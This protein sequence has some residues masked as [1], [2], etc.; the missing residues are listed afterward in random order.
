[1]KK[2]SNW[3]RLD[4]QAKIFPEVY[5]KREPHMF[6]IQVTLNE[7]IEK[8]ILQAAV[9]HMLQR[10]PMFKVKLSTGFFW[11]Y[12]EENHKPFKVT[13]MPH[14]INQYMDFRANNDYLMR[15]FYRNQTIAVEVFHTLTD[16]TGLTEFVKS[17]AFEYL[18]LKGYKISPD[19]M[20]M[21]KRE[22]P[23]QDEA[24]DPSIA[25]YNKK[26]NK[27]IKEKAPFKVSGTYTENYEIK[28]IGGNFKTSDLIPLVKENNTT[29]TKYIAAVLI[30]SIYKTMIEYRTQLRKNQHPIKI[31]VPVNLRKRFPS[32]TMRNFVNIVSV[33]ADVSRDNV[34]FEEILVMVE[35]ELT[36]KTSQ[37]ELTRIMSEYVSYEKNILVRMIP[38]FIKKYFLKIGYKLL[39]SSLLTMTLSNVGK[40]DYPESMKPYIK[41]MG[42]ML[43]SGKSTPLNCAVI[44]SNNTLKVSFTS[45][46]IESH[47]Q[48]EFFRH[49]TQLG[50]DVEIESNYLEEKS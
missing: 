30:H 17:L 44:S 40:V 27:R 10:F 32:Q 28:Y 3:Y 11:A 25:Y 38:A 46:I 33:C 7:T 13:E 23:L 35:K 26:N 21:T 34:T 45:N 22:K 12:L 15:I 29:I 2:T 20:I 39:G 4:N 42:F 18:S 24:E 1:M 48:R 43:S 41:S 9:D 37:D 47:I 14:S 31:G 19:N 8:E 49:F 5:H 36:E 16:G 50:L 6:R